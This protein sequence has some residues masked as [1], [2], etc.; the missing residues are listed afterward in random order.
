MALEGT[1]VIQPVETGASCDDLDIVTQDVEF[2]DGCP[3]LP[4]LNMHIVRRGQCATLQK[5][6]RNRKGDPVDLTNC[7]CTVSGSI[8]ESDSDVMCGVWFR[9]MEATGLRSNDPI[10]NI[11]ATIVTPESG[12]VQVTLPTELV[13]CPAVYKQDWGVYDNGLLVYSEEGWMVVENGM[14]GLTD[15]TRRNEGPP[16]IREIRLGIRDNAPNENLLLDDVEFSDIEIGYA[17]VR[18]IREFFEVPPP[19]DLMFTTKDFFFKEHWIK[20]IQGY[21]YSMAEAWY[22]RNQLDTSAG[23]VKIDDLNKER[24]YLRA[25]QLYLKEWREFILHKK[26]EINAANFAGSVNST[27]GRFGSR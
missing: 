16:S 25:S 18:P 11:Q 10:F 7:G 8:S 1:P 20:A 27:Y 15:I 19:L 4:K 12:L 9:A 21:L 2:R 14:F 5:T 13:N 6:I 24:E 17:M 22:R 23:G 3:V 26:V